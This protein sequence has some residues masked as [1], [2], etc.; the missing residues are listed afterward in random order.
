MIY[1]SI[2]L[3]IYLSVYLSVYRLLLIHMFVLTVENDF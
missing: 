2:Y 3:S 1:I